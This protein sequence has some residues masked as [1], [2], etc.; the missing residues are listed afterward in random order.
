MM[1]SLLLGR[2]QVQYLILQEFFPPSLLVLSESISESRPSTSSLWTPGSPGE[3]SPHQWGQC[4]AACR[5]F[6][7]NSQPVFVLSYLS[8]QKGSVCKTEAQKLTQLFV[9]TQVEV[10]LNS[11]LKNIWLFPCI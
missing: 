1:L 10:F 3:K 6:L 11:L 8:F 5:S 4:L 7:Q 2:G 9:V